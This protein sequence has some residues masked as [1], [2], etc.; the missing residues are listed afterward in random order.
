MNKIQ[1]LLINM[2]HK[3]FNQD[4]KKKIS[5]HSVYLILYRIT[6]IRLMLKITQ[7]FIK[8]KG[9]RKKVYSQPF[10]SSFK[11]RT[12]LTSPWTFRLM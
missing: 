5:V 6:N 7:P 2:H 9:K 3:Y 12:M 1:A 11:F 4:I 8:K 10:F